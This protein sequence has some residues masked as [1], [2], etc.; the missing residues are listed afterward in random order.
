[1]KD[2][3][4]EYIVLREIV[5]SNDSYGNTDTSRL[6]E[7]SKLRRFETGL[8]V[9]IW[10]DEGNT[11]QKTGH[12][13]RIEFQGDKGDSNTHNWVPL[14]VSDEPVVPRGIKH[15]LNEKELDDVKKFVILN[16][17]LLLK[18]GTPGFGIVEFGKRMVRV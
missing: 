9:D 17:E 15:D 10:I 4:D 12:A 8:P 13:R 2:P 14:T 5:L 6:L 16:K 3:I 11:F 1:M 18:L 7:M